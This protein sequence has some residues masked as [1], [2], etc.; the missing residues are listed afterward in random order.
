MP[1]E[2]VKQPLPP[3]ERNPAGYNPKPAHPEDIWRKFADG[4]RRVVSAEAVPSAPM[5]LDWKRS[6]QA[7]YG[8]DNANYHIGD[9][10]PV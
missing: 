9:Q 1:K 5:R 10:P 3:E 7:F 6:M 2:R 4:W 8:D